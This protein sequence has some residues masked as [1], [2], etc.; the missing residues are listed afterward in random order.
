MKSRQG[1]TLMELMVV[2][3][4]VAIL[5]AIA[6]PSYQNYILKA[7]IKE[8]QSNLIA[9]SL[10]AENA[11]QRMLSYPIADYTTTAQIQASTTFKTWNPT[12][13]AFSYQYKSTDGITY[14]LIAQGVET[15]LSSC[16]VQLTSQGQKTLSNCANMTDWVK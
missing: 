4:I 6:I 2:I 15:K 13:A 11:Y 9:M 10:S 14:T 5:S 3:I 16:K 7:K 8:A 1:F 12:S